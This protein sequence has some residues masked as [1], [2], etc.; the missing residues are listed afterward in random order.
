ML[1]RPSTVPGRAVSVTPYQ[2]IGE[3]AMALR[4]SQRGLSL[5]RQARLLLAAEPAQL[6]SSSSSASP[7]PWQQQAGF[8]SGRGLQEPTNQSSQ[9]R[10]PPINYGIR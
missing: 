10:P 2:W 6:V 1:C 5:A 9:R 8:A 3:Q 7:A 4:A